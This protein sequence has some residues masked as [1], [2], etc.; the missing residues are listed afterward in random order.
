MRCVVSGSRDFTDYDVLLDAIA[1]SNFEI[2]EIV[3][4][5]CLNEDYGNA[6][7]KGVDGLGERYAHENKIP[8]KYFPA[9]WKTHGRAA[10][11]YRN[12]QMAEYA[13]ALIAIKKPSSAGTANMIRC[14]NEQG[15]KVYVKLIK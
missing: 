10:G 4:G 1:E 9:D 7:S 12:S 8:V 14:A 3:S 11:P 15:L 2:T 5:A 6:Y 13:D